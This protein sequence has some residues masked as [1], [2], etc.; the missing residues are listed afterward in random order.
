MINK[1]NLKIRIY[2]Y[3]I[4]KDNL[5]IK[6]D[7]RIKKNNKQKRHRSIISIKIEKLSIIIYY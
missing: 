5:K 1:D 4:I 7:K 2:Y 6:K 3:Y